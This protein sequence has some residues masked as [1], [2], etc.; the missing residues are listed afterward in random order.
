MVHIKNNFF[1]KRIEI[2]SP[3]ILRTSYLGSHQMPTNIPPS[4][5]MDG[6]TPSPM[7]GFSRKSN[8][9]LIKPVDLTTDL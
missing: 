6:R 7:R 5:L 9:D 4:S 8:L 3:R 2:L 1:L